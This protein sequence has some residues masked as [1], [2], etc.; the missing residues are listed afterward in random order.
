ME[1]TFHAFL[2]RHLLQPLKQA[3]FPAELSFIVVFAVSA[4][5]HEVIM[6]V[7]LN[8]HLNYKNYGVFGAWA[9]HGIFGQLGAILAT[10]PLKKYPRMVG[11][12]IFWV[13]F[14]VVGQPLAV[15]NLA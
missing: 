2:K 1:P 12:T 10:D 8:T 9:F 13:K 7:A 4:F 5:F 14:C 3:G 6:V 15:S 11:N